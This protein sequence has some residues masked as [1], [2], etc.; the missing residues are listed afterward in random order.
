MSL[1][2]NLKERIYSLEFL[3]LFGLQKNI[4]VRAKLHDQAFRYW[5]NC[6]TILFKRCDRVT[7]VLSRSGEMV[8]E[9]FFSNKAVDPT[10]IHY[11]AKPNAVSTWV[12]ACVVRKFNFHHFLSFILIRRVAALGCSFADS[13]HFFA[14][15]AH[16]REIARVA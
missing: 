12:E 9:G 4:G 1:I 2:C 16:E 15:F 7:C 5:F 11:R 3:E 6:S 10:A 13:F 14:N 8:R